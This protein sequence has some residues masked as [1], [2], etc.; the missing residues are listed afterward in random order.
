MSGARFVRFEGS[1]QFNKVDERGAGDGQRLYARS[2]CLP[3]T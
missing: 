1:E 2:T 3:A